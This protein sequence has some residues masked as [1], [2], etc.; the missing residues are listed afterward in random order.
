V[1]VGHAH[2]Q[3]FQRAMAALHAGNI[4]E[5]EHLLKAV[6]RTKPRHVGALNVLGIVLTQQQ[7]FDDAET[8]LRRALQENARSD[9]TLYN[10]GL[11]L[12]AL[13]RPAEALDRFTA[14]LAI[15][16]TIAETWNNRGTVFND[17]GRYG[18]AI[19]D[20]DHALR[21]NPRYA[22]A[23]C[24]KGKTLAILKRPQDALRAYDSALAS[25]PDLAEAWSGRGETSW[26]LKRYDEALAACDKALALRPDLAEAWLGRG[27]VLAKRGRYDE[28]LAA[29]DRVLALR[30][31]L[32]ELWLGRGNVYHALKRHD[33]SLRAYDAALAAKPELVE[34]WYG[35]GNVFTSLRQYESAFAAYD[36]ALALQPDCAEAWLGRGN[37]FFASRWYADA[38][39]AYDKA[40]QLQPDLAEAWLGRGSVYLERADYDYALAAYERALTADP[41]LAEAW[42]GRGNVLFERR[43]YPAALAAYDKAAGLKSDLDYMAGTRL[44]AK[45]HMCDWTNLDTEVTTCLSAIRQGKLA[46]TPFALLALPAS[47]AAQQQCAKRYVADRAAPAPRS[48]AGSHAHDRLR[49]AYLSAD[50][51]EHPVAYLAA[52]LYERHDRSRFEITGISFG[53]DRNSPMRERLQGAFDRFIDV[54]DQTE[55]DIAALVS[56]LGIDIAVDLM[57]HT[58]NGRPGIFARR[59]APIQVSYLGYLG[60]MG[61]DYIDYVIADAVALP[62]DQQCYY[63]EKIVHLPDCFLVNDDSLTI[64]P[65]TPTR[66]EVGLPGDGF[67]FSSFNNS[68][69]LAP[70]VFELWMRLLEAVDGSVLWLAEANPD[71]VANLR[72]EAERCGVDPGRLVFAPHVPL[73]EHMARQRLADLFLD[74]TPYNA[75]AT[76]AAALWSGVPILTMLGSTF[77]GRMAASMLHAAGLPEL[78]AQS[79][80]DYEALVLN[81]ATDPALCA[82]LKQRLATN[83]GTCS[84]FDTA[85]F[86]RHIEDAY[87]TMWQIHQQG[88]PPASFAVKAT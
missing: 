79:L 56:E 52:G 31:G 19:A 48:R 88:L 24:N 25:R 64:S 40:L 2:D 41:E 71:M 51:G 9:A 67:V 86:A 35:R 38:L 44:L 22:D 42:N 75:G 55:E 82:S 29:Y 5:A 60:T 27:N 83:R 4:K 73:A 70:A 7:K 87:L 33:E 30:T 43:C 28:A 50:F 61:A 18:E 74:T 54:E 34:A 21:I 13:K 59:P 14:A 85:R 46:S 6:L 23:L 58:R 66:E 32:A 69:K 63:T 47:A 39:S 8:Y 84:L 80:S 15:N 57:G 17:L 20:F 65:H 12:K 81:V 72:R 62:H 68:Y 16:P 3:T 77:V 78:V 49:V 37:A 76:A 36:K 53:R 45:L 11:I 1:P 10:Y 26:M